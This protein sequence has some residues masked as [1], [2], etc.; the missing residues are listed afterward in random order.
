MNVRALKDKLEVFFP[1]YFDKF[2]LSSQNFFTAI[3]GGPN[4]LLTLILMFSQELSF[5]LWIR[6]CTCRSSVL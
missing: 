1:S 6:T 5:Y 3:D 2:V 4:F